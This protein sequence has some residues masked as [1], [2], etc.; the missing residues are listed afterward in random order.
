MHKSL[1][2]LSL[3][4]FL[5][6]TPSFAAQYECPSAFGPFSL[7][8]S[9]FGNRGARNW[10]KGNLE[11]AEKQT[12]K[13]IKLDPD[14]SMW[15]Q[16]LGFILNDMGRYEEA[17]LS[18]ERSLEIDKFWCN[19]Y[20]T[21][22]ALALG[23][24][25][26]FIAKDYSES[27]TNLN[28]AIRLAKQERIDDRQA[29]RLYFSLSYNYTEPDSSY[30]DLDMALDLKQKALSLDPDNLFYQISI[31]SVLVKQGSEK[32]AKPLIEDVLQRQV[33]SP[34]PSPDIYGYLAYIYALMDN[35][36]KAAQYI[37][38]AIDIDPDAA[39]YLLEE[40]DGDF[41]NVASSEDMKLVIEKA[42][43][44]QAGN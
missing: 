16:N 26:V 11:A 35:A 21:G 7:M 9:Y 38:A 8:G 19:A 10:E 29:A 3:I 42:R 17:S 31:A 4:L 28:L 37:D 30:F 13:A 40:L 39:K 1:F 33:K 34:H 14:C 32:M 2:A 6:S 20:K 5:I 24:Y 27:I 18:W 41:K 15:H 43:K 22:S 25:Y 23:E 36:Q 12:Q 44:L